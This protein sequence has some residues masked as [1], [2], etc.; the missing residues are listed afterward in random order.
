MFKNCLWNRRFWNPFVT[1][2]VRKNQMRLSLIIYFL[3]TACVSFRPYP[4]GLIRFPTKTRF[5]C[6]NVNE[7]VKYHQSVCISYPFTSSMGLCRKLN[8]SYIYLSLFDFIC[9]WYYIRITDE[10]ITLSCIYVIIICWIYIMLVLTTTTHVIHVINQWLIN[11]RCLLPY[12]RS[13]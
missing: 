6:Q 3:S 2:F 10:S 7:S 1:S 8:W 13:R 11:C 12:Q 4:S 5:C 9:L